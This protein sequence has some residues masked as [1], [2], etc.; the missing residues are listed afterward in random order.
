MSVETFTRMEARDKRCGGARWMVRLREQ[1]EKEKSGGR[2]ADRGRLQ[3]MTL[4]Y[5]G[6]AKA[7]DQRLARADQRVIVAQSAP[8]FGGREHC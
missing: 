7:P 2:G 3:S 8:N 4:L 6:L 1:L 5:R